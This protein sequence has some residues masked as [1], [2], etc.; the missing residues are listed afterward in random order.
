MIRRNATS[1]PRSCC[2]KAADS[3]D[4]LTQPQVDSLKAFYAGGV[5]AHGNPVFPD[6]AMGDEE[7]WGAWIVGQGPGSGSGLQYLQN[8]FRYMVTEDPNGIS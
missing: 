5:D 8:Y 3:L 2:A 1:I 6:F 4:C 7:G